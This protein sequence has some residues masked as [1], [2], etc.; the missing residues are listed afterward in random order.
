MLGILGAVQ[1]E[2]VQ[3]SQLLPTATVTRFVDSMVTAAR[4]SLKSANV[5]LTQCQM[6]VG[7]ILCCIKI[8]QNI[9]LCVVKV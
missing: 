4:T 8:K 7:A 1:L 9:L 6:S 2:Y 5:S 3:E